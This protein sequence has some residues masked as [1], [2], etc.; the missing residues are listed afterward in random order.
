[1]VTTQFSYRWIVVLIS[2]IAAAMVTLTIFSEKAATDN[3]FTC[4]RWQDRHL[5]QVDGMKADRT[6]KKF[7]DIPGLS[8][9][10]PGCILSCPPV[11]SLATGGDKLKHHTTRDES[12][13][14][15]F[16]WSLV[17]HALNVVLIVVHGETA[18]ANTRP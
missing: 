6:T 1:M 18:L 7:C 9:A 17:T 12:V 16:N 14:D 2:I 11:L 10:Y 15:K 5:S 8:A 3:V 13:S 4:S